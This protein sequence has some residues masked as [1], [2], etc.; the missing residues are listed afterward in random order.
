MSGLTYMS[1]CW[2]GRRVPAASATIQREFGISQP[3]VSQRLDALGTGL[4]R[5][6]RG[7]PTRALDT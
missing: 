6:G 4:A 3:A 1:M 7:D 2:D 5:G